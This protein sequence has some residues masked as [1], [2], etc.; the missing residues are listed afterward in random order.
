MKD[1][2]DYLAEEL[3]KRAE[4]ISETL[5]AGG[6]K[7]Y[8]DYRYFVGM[9]NGVRFAMGKIAD[10]KDMQQRGEEMDH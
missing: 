2:M 6:A 1:V 7:S 5:L 4:D 10:I 8:D 9:A 3:N